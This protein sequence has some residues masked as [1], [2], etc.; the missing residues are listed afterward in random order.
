M[1]KYKGRELKDL[2]KKRLIELLSEQ[3]AVN[4]K[5]QETIKELYEVI[6]EMKNKKSRIITP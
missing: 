2:G 5:M 3:V 4:L 6:E 1:I